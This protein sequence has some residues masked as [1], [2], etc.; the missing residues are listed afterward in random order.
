MVRTSKARLDDPRAIVD[1]DGLVQRLHV[2]HTM[3]DVAACILGGCARALLQEDVM[4]D[5]QA[6]NWGGAHANVS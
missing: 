6:S 4:A 3:A 1:N 5:Y 2:A